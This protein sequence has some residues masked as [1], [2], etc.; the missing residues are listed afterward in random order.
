MQRC[1]SISTSQHDHTG[2]TDTTYWCM[3]IDACLLMHA[4]WCMPASPSAYTPEKQTQAQAHS[5][6]LVEAQ[7]QTQT[8]T[9]TETETE[10][11]DT[12]RK[13]KHWQRERDQQVVKLC[14]HVEKALGCLLFEDVGRNHCHKHLPICH[15]SLCYFLLPLLFVAAATVC[16]PRNWTLPYFAQSSHNILLSS[17]QYIPTYLIMIYRITYIYINVYINIYI[18]IHTYTYTY[19]YLH[20][21]ICIHLCEYIYVNIHTYIH[22]YKYTNI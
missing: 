13:H 4:Y 22:I 18:F 20:M 12:R 14:T 19:L 2:L 6:A 9:E 16:P 7:T 15:V 1:I 17:K 8:Q 3:P 10:T 11:Q 5:Q 21:Y